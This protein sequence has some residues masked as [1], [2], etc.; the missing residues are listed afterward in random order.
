MAGRSAVP[1]QEMVAGGVL[2]S[3]R[4]R[5]AG[6]HEGRNKLLEQGLE[7]MRLGRVNEARAQIFLV[8]IPKFA[9]QIPKEDDGFV[10]LERHGDRL[11]ES[12]MV[13]V[14][15]ANVVRLSV[16]R[17]RVCCQPRKSAP[18]RLVIGGRAN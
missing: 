13:H 3:R 4:R 8:L 17:L 14:R 16:V 15:L 10:P 11:V 18:T 6:V 12:V 7:T 2:N 1:S 5:R 9:G